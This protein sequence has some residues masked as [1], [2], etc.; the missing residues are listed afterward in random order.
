VSAMKADLLQGRLVRLT[1]E[2][3]QVMADQ[4]SKW[5]QTSEYWRLMSS[6]PN[7]LY[8]RKKLEEWFEE[9]VENEPD[10][11]L[12]FAIRRLEDDR[13]IG[14]IALDGI[15]YQH[16]NA[17]ASVG[18]GDPANWGQ[19]HGTDAMRTLLR[20]AFEE[21]NLERVSLTVFEYNPRALRSYQKA[22]FVVEGRSREF[23]RR[24]GRRW[25]MLFMGILKYEWQR[26]EARDV[27]DTPKG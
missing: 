19:G 20:Y 6:D 22:G 12:N 18:I 13:L 7:R 21:L 4:F 8:S 25:D 10:G 24:D 16:G 1:C 14:A 11:E 3:P 27:K 23:L 26:R 15:D 17:F 9:G 2:D 5:M